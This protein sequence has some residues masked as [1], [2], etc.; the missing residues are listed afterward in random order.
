MRGVKIMASEDQSGELQVFG[1]KS[2]N[3]TWE[4]MTRAQVWEVSHRKEAM[5]MHALHETPEVS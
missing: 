2:D 3:I 5:S 4:V 1:W